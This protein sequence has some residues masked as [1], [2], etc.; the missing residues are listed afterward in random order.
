[1]TS[2]HKLSCDRNT[3]GVERISSHQ[4]WQKWGFSHDQV[5]LCVHHP[6]TIISSSL[7]GEGVVRG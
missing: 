4:L 7:P 6:V 3:I 1:M 5:Y 2:H